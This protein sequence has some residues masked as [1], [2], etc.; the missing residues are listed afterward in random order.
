MGFERSP[1]VGQ[2]VSCLWHKEGNWVK[3]VQNSLFEGGRVH[4]VVA[5]NT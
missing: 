1:L 3:L 4:T 2:G 5:G